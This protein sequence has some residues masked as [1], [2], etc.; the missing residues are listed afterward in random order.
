MG[1]YKILIKIVDWS[2]KHYIVGLILYPD[3][4]Y[5]TILALSLYFIEV[6]AYVS[7]LWVGRLSLLALS[8]CFLCNPEIL[9]AIL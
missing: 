7:C 1:K 3:I 2:N 6:L 5:G 8:V 9:Y 4:A